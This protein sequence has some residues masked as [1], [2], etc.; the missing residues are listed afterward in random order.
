MASAKFSRTLIMTKVTASEGDVLLYE[1]TFQGDLGAK[2]A[3]RKLKATDG[4]R[5]AVTGD[6]KDVVFATD[7]IEEKREMTLDDFIKHSKVVE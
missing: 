7:T 4:Y 5:S 1:E 6:S 3:E 2:A